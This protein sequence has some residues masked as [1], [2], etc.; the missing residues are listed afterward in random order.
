MAT[1]IALPVV[2]YQ[3]W[4]FVAPID[5]GVTVPGTVS[6]LGNRKT[7]QHLEGGIIKELHVN[8][9]DKVKVTLRFRGREMAHQ[10]LG[11]ELLNRVAADVV[12]SERAPIYVL[13][14]DG[15]QFRELIFQNFYD[16]DSNRLFRGNPFLTDSQLYNASRAVAMITIATMASSRVKPPAA[17]FIVRPSAAGRT[18]PAPRRA[19]AGA[20]RPGRSP[21]RGTPCRSPSP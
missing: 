15:P 9:G 3:V 1:L 5:A 17:R 6:V 19:R 18:A 20:A 13:R 11:L 4:A 10:D 14:T 7:V 12:E 2:L 21:A 16:T 8:E